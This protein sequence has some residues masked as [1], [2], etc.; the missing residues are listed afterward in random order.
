MPERQIPNSVIAEVSDALGS[1]YFNH[2]TLNTLFQRCGAPGDVPQGNCVN[3]CAQW[4]RRAN[5]DPN[6]DA[7]SLLGGVLEEFMEVE[8]HDPHLIERRQRVQRALAKHGL[9]YHTGGQILGAS[10]G[11][12]TRS[13]QQIIREHDLGG[14]ETEFQRALSAVAADPPTAITAACAIIESLCKV[15]I[16]DNNLE[17]PTDQSIRPLWR[18][19]Q[20]H[21]GLQPGT[22]ANQDLT[23]IL[24]GIAS[25]IDGIG[26]LRTHTGSAHGHGR[27]SFQVEARHARLAIHSAHTLATFIIETWNEHRT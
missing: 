26:A 18:V 27:D 3:K 15:Y 10:T 25:V 16:K 6:V 23:R 24:G 19:V 1:H 12:P 14:L 13:L 5:E 4:L 7:Y 22:V 2:T 9:S 21:L 17:M 8:T 11:T 20:R